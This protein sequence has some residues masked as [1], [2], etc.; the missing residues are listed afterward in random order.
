MT[1]TGVGLVGLA[2]TGST[3]VVV[4]TRL[5]VQALKDIDVDITLD[6]Y[7]QAAPGRTRAAALP[8]TAGR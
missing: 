6:P 5:F 4:L 2:A 1:R 8:V 7:G 3:A